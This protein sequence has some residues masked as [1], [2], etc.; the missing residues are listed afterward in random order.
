M[1]PKLESKSTAPVNDVATGVVAGGAGG[2][3]MTRPPHPVCWLPAVTVAVMAPDSVRVPVG[4]ADPAS[5][6]EVGVDEAPQLVELRK[7]AST[8][9]APGTAVHRIPRSA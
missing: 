8:A 6:P 1:A 7:S 5:V 2:K 9:N 4:A 3:L